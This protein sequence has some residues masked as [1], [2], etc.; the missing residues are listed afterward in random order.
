MIVSEG[1]T[2]YYTGL[3]LHRVGLRDARM[4]RR[5]R[6]GVGEGETGRSFEWVVQNSKTSDEARSARIP[7]PTTCAIAGRPAPGTPATTSP[8][9]DAVRERGGFV[10]L[11]GE[12][13]VLDR[14]SV[15]PDGLTAPHRTCPDQARIV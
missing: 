2:A 8:D 1:F 12:A 9:L 3:T 13:Y 5:R 15:S 7:S 4:S 14:E 6:E 10:E 11:K